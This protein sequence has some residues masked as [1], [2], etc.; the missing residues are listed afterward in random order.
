MLLRPGW[1]AERRV[2]SRCTHT[3]SSWAAARR[4]AWREAGG[5]GCASVGDYDA[6]EGEDDEAAG[7]VGPKV[8]VEGGRRWKGVVSSTPPW[9]ESCF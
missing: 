9:P 2:R 8:A 6:L 3:I 5:G 1:P 4:K 7:A